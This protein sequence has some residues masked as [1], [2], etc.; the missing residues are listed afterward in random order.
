MTIGKNF[1]PKSKI[2]PAIR[3]GEVVERDGKENDLTLDYLMH[4]PRGFLNEY[5]PLV[6]QT[7]RWIFSE[8]PHRTGVASDFS[9]ARKLGRGSNEYNNAD[10]NIRSL[11]VEF[12]NKNNQ[13]NLNL[14]RRVVMQLISNEILGMS[15]L[16]PIWNDMRVHEVYV[17]GPYDIQVEMDD[18][19]HR[20]DGASFENQEHALE[21]CS[22]LLGD[23]N[24]T[25]DSTNVVAESR[26]SDGSRFEATHPA[27]CPEGPNIDI[28]RHDSRFWTISDLVHTGMSNQAMLIDL[29]RYIRLG[30]STLVIGGTSTGKTT[31]LNALS[32]IFPN[33]QRII[34]IEDTLELHINPNKY[35]AA[36]ME[37]RPAGLNG[38]GEVSLRKL[39]K[40]SLRLSPKIIVIGETRG[41]EAYDLVE[42]ANTGHQ[43]FSTLHANNATHAIS[44]VEMAI[45]QGGELVGTETLGAI[46]SA[47]AIIVEITKY[48]RLGGRTRRII[49]GIHEVDTRLSKNDAGEPVLGTKPLWKFETKGIGK[50]GSVIGDWVKVSELSL[51]RQ[52]M[53][54]NYNFT[55]P[56]TWN[57]MLALENVSRK[58]RMFQD[59]TPMFMTASEYENAGRRTAIRNSNSAPAPIPVPMR[60]NENNV[61]QRQQRP[62]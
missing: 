8:I 59:D 23:Y 3:N 51:E 24:K 60:Q 45:S 30:L 40:T 37:A 26:L 2:K 56:L 62:E 31:V 28:R 42:G 32:G 61:Q 43:V 16:D 58:R 55:H 11:S 29:E 27:I 21:F 57:Q 50:D 9:E 1:T 48:M 36:P 18:G 46:Q 33:G 34:T 5:W 13:V 47:F 12:L 39:V 17:N 7:K 6:N 35:I 10:S 44:R 49:T 53:L 19:L 41:A 25:L 38:S 52:A 4:Q 20:V 14:D 15:I 22:K 54:S